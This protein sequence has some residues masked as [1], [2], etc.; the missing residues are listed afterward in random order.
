[1]TC[2]K[3]GYVLAQ[4]EEE[5]PDLRL[6]A[7]GPR[8]RDQR[9]DVLDLERRLLV[10]LGD[11]GTGAIL[12]PLHKEEEAVLVDHSLLNK[13]ALQGRE[14]RPAEGGH[15]EA[16]RAGLIAVHEDLHEGDLVLLQGLLHPEIRDPRLG[17]AGKW[18]APGVGA[19]DVELLP[20]LF[21]ALVQDLVEA[22]LVL[23]VPRDRVAVPV[24]KAEALPMLRRE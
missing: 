13:A 5:D 15:R 17:E 18:L 24:N 19:L 23:A 10:G 8:A 2:G 9:G 14:A 3:G 16:D 20:D 6:A 11:D 21:V 22:V 4:F 1:M 12:A 7:L